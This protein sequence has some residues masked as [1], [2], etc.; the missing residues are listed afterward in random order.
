MEGAITPFVPS[1]N[2]RLFQRIGIYREI[3]A[4]ILTD[5]YVFVLHLAEAIENLKFRL[6]L[7]L[8]VF[9]A[10][11]SFVSFSSF[12]PDM[13]MTLFLNKLIEHL[14]SLLFTEVDIIK[15]IGYTYVGIKG[16]NENATKFEYFKTIV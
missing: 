4:L 1:L 10:I 15:Y 11:L 6:S 12:F 2:P 9:Y 5:C 7:I 3:I 8:L 16:K 13:T 14:H